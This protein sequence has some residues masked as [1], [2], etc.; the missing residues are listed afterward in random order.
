M[1]QLSERDVEK[2][3]LLVSAG[4]IPHLIR[5]CSACSQREVKVEIAYFIGQIFQD[6]KHLM[7]SYLACEGY[8][9]QLAFLDLA[10]ATNTDLVMIAIDSFLVIF[11]ECISRQ[12]SPERKRSRSRESKDSKK[13]H[14]HR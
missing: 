14:H 4:L 5:L 7:S 3:Q 13:P 8:R 10:Y 1:N 6:P 9:I 11:E 2:Q 12:A